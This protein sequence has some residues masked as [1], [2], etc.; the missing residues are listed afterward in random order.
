VNELG[1]YGVYTLI[2]FHQDVLHPSVCGEGLPTFVADMA[3]TSHNCSQNI[4]PEIFKI[5]GVC[6]SIKDYNYKVD[7]STGYPLVS[8][9]LKSTFAM[10]YITPEV[11]SAFNSMWTVEAV[12]Q[13]IQNYWTTVA[14]KFAQNP[15]VLGYDLINEPWYEQYSSQI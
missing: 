13:L 10:Y 11:S 9:C 5:L 15:Y 12:K 6:K 4:I 8:E 1:N 3:I 7:P 2:D 14:T